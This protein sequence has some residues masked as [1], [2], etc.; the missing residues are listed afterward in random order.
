MR[1]PVEMARLHCGSLHLFHVIEAQ[2]A[3]P[4]E[5]VIELIQKANDAMEGLSV[6]PDV[7]N[8]FGRHC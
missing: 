4:A 1:V 6:E 8:R 3:A 2:P 7:F 5:V